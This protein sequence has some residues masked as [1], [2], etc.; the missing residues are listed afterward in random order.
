M[1]LRRF[2]INSITI[3]T[4]LAL[5]ACSRSE[6]RSQFTETPTA[7]VSVTG[8][9]PGNY[10]E[11]LIV[12]GQARQYR[13]HIPPTY[14][15][16]QA[17]PLVV[18]LHGLG[19]NA[20]QQEQVSQM[21]TK[22]DQIGFI[23]VYPEGLGNPQTWHVGSRA[24]ADADLQFIRDLIAHLK[25]QL[26]IAPGHIYA[27]GIS[28]GAQMSN[29]LGCEMADVFAAIAPVSGGYPPSQECRPIHPVAVVAF[30][31]IADQIL[32]YEGQGRLLLPVRE[33]ASAWAARNGCDSTPTIT[34]QQDRKSVV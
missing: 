23:V 16:G 20:A 7:T 11:T 13:L 17:M 15:P 5:V 33:W 26:N 31:G 32:P 9:A 1:T 24:E 18:N 19:S 8:Y 22:A 14:K 4:A 3:A 30:H 10:V 28:N 27:T 21:S 6:R 29:R 2:L 12:N 34:F 25:A